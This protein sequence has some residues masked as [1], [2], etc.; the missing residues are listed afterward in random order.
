MQEYGR[1]WPS[2]EPSGP[3]VS[4]EQW[5]SWEQAVRDVAIGSVDLEQWRIDNFLEC[6]IEDENKPWV[7]E[8]VD[9]T[10]T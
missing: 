5:S 7:S 6:G 2:P 8:D 10:N 3:S 1:R 9:E 4:M